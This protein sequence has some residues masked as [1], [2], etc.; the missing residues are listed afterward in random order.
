MP[1]GIIRV[2]EKTDLVGRAL[3]VLRGGGGRVGEARCPNAASGH[4]WGFWSFGDLRRNGLALQPS[5]LGE[6]DPEAVASSLI[7]AGHLGRGVPELLLNV[8]LV[9]LGRGRQSGA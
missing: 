5:G 4:L 9:D 1:H 6:I 3:S 7:A 8:T 2:A